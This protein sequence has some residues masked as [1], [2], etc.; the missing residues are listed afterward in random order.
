MA[1]RTPEETDQLF[2]RYANGGDLAGLAALYEPRG[3]LVAQDGT[4]ATGPAAIREALSGLVGARPQLRMNVHRVVRAGDDLA[5]LYND[6]TMSATGPDG[7]TVEMA[8][9][10]T[11]VVRRQADDTWLFAVDDPW[12]RG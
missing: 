8:G 9:K 10:A 11:E 4:V 12:A 1:A 3:C 6:W 7:A 2:A 5:V